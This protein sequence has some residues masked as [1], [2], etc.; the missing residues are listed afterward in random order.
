MISPS[1][2]YLLLG[3]S[4]SQPSSD[5]KKVFDLQWCDLEYCVHG[6]YSYAHTENIF[7]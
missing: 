1:S 6:R 5:G 2:N 7:I 4:V 3:I